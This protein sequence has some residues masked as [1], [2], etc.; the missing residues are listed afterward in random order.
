[1][2]MFHYILASFYNLFF[3]SYSLIITNLWIGDI[4]AA[5]NYEFLKEN[6][7]DIIVNCSKDLPF[8]YEINE[9]AKDLNLETYRIPVDD[10]L[11]EKDFIEM[12]KYFSSVLPVILNHYLDNKRILV[13]C[14]M[15]KQRS[16]IFTAAL[17]KVMLD[18]GI[19][20]QNLE[21]QSDKKKEFD[22]IIK[23]ILSKRYQAF[24]FGYR[25]NFKKTYKRY[26][27]IE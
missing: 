14:Y 23:F 20:I 8:I 1:M 4:N 27:N 26:F 7:I 25:V 15:G 2:Q 21:K 19:K 6:N 10:S 5:H 17:L 18:N 24:T 3:D 22:N 16:A 12:E 9:K 13:H 11:L